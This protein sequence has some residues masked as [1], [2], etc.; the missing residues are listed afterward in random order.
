MMI[1]RSTI[2]IAGIALLCAGSGCR[3]QAEPGPARYEREIELDRAA[4]AREKSE[5]SEAGTSGRY[6]W[7][8][9]ADP[10]VES[11]PQR[12]ADMESSFRRESDLH[13]QV[14]YGSRD[15]NR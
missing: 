15:E 1:S 7:Q 11:L 8:G 4:L 3:R 2:L 12:V 10:G 14:L 5:R 6:P 13:R 9:R